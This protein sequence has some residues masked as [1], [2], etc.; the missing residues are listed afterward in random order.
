M[1]LSV[2]RVL[3]TGKKMLVIIDGNDDNLLTR[4]RLEMVVHIQCGVGV[5]G[6]FGSF[7]LIPFCSAVQK[8]KPEQLYQ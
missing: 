8:Y 4:F 2:A 3:E 5:C 1:G 6:M 7:S